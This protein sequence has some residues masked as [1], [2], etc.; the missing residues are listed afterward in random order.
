MDFAIISVL[1]FIILLFI[2]NYLYYTYNNRKISIF[3]YIEYFVNT[4]D[5]HF[6][7]KFLKARDRLSITINI[8]NILL[9]LIGLYFLI[10]L[11]LN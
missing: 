8:L 10:D 7:L 6:L 1:L 4:R 11:F 5:H 9:C 3:R 2:R